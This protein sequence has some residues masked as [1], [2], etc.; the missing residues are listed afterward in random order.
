MYLYKLKPDVD[1]SR[2]AA[3]LMTLRE[4]IPQ[5][6]AMEVGV[7]FKSAANAYDLLE[8]CT[9]EDHAAFAAFGADAYHEEIRQY[10]KTVQVD[11]VKI[12]YEMD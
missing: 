7:N 2:V 3:K 9:F 5:I 1:P 8:C 12:D 6:S 11:G 10:M 4:R